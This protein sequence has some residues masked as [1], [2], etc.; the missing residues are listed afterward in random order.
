M[1]KLDLPIFGEVLQNQYGSPIINLQHF[2]Y[3]ADLN[4][5]ERKLLLEIAA[6]N[7]APKGYRIGFLM[8]PIRFTVA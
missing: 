7:M 8:T 6:L 2:S 4:E 5:T 3:G 1:H